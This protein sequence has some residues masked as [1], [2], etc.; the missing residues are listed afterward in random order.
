MKIAIFTTKIT[1]L[2]EYNVFF[3]V[4]IYTMIETLN[5]ENFELDFDLE[6]YLELWNWKFSSN[7][8][9]FDVKYG[10]NLKNLFWAIKEQYIKSKDNL[11]EIFRQIESFFQ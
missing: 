10:W 8:V 3:H 11:V 1:I 5:E 9:M 6:K 4:D 2:H 7:F